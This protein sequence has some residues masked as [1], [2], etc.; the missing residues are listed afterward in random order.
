[1]P[2]TIQ[3]CEHGQLLDQIGELAVCHWQELETEFSDRVPEPDRN[4][5]DAMAAAGGLIAFSA[6]L[7]G[8]VVGYASAFVCRHP[9]YDMVL[10]HHDTLYLHPAHRNGSTGLRLMKAIEQE[11]FAR[12]AER[13]MWTAKLGSAFERILLGKG[14]QVEETIYCKEL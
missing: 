9:H 14:Y 12:G 3:P 10:A 2:I 6:T 7:D 13:M 1:M 5:Y 11:A 4:V 8:V